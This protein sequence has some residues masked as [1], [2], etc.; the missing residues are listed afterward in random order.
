MISI[1]FNC[2]ILQ[3]LPDIFVGIQV[4]IP[5]TVVKVADMRRY[6]IAYPFIINSV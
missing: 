5:D 4:G 3:P 6:I 1:D 2:F